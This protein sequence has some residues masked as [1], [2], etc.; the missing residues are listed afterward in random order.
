[1]S[2]CTCVDILIRFVFIFVVPYLVTAPLNMGARFGF[3]M[4]FIALCGTIFIFFQV[5]E[6]M[7]RSLEEMDELY[8]VSSVGCVRARA[9]PRERN[10][11]RKR[12]REA[13]AQCRN[14]VQRDIMPVVRR[15]R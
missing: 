1:M 2:F 10:R 14:A 12:N 7:G 4:G 9:R 15:D 5:P 13:R 6:T 3:V 11:K 8:A